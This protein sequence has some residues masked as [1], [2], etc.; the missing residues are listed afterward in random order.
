MSDFADRMKLIL[1]SSGL[2]N[3]EEIRAKLAPQII[4]SLIDEQLMIQETQKRS[5]KV[6]DVEVDQGFAALAQQNKMTPEQFAGMI[7]GSGVNIA[8]M[9]RQIKAQIGWGKI[10]QKVMRPQITVSDSDIDDYI[11]RITANKGKEEYLLAEIFLPVETPMEENNIRQL[12]QKLT[13]EIRGGKA[14]FFKVAQQFSKAPGAA[15]GGN[16]GWI[17]QGQL[18]QEL[19]QVIPTLTVN[20]VSTPIRST[21][22]YHILLLRDKR[23][24]TDETM[25]SREQVMSTLGTERLDRAQRRYLMDLKN[26][27]FIENRVQS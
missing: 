4:A 18:Q 22:G 15:Q 27:A 6:E 14:P 12:A 11:K 3:S 20:N 25:P 26:S 19:D 23:V 1:I 24:L 13:N 16:L 8:T 2:P 7:S 9:K 21:S 10:I 17:Q 5:I